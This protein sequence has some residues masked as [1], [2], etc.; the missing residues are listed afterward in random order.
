MG[1]IPGTITKV[2]VLN[3]FINLCGNSCQWEFLSGIFEY[4]KK[5]LLLKFYTWIFL[6]YLWAHTAHYIDQRKLLKGNLL[7]WQK[8]FLDLFCVVLE[9]RARTVHSFI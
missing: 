5:Y 8:Y 4:L 1:I 3:I 9:D 6:C 2:Q 7:L